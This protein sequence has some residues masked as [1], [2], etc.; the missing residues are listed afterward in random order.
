MTYPEWA[1]E[2]F[3]GPEAAYHENVWNRLQTIFSMD[4]KGADA[5]MTWANGFVSNSFT[6]GTS[7][8]LC[9]EDVILHQAEAERN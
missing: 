7:P 5:L 8:A 9:A 2:Q 3:N 4:T 1:K 6:R